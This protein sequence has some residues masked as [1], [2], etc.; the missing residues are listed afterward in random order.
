MFCNKCSLWFVDLNKC[1]KLS[2]RLLNTLVMQCKN[3]FKGKGYVCLDQRAY[4]R[5]SHQLERKERCGGDQGS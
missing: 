2:A 1:K 4:T 5:T 3:E